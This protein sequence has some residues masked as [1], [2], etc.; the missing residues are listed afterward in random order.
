MGAKVHELKTPDGDKYKA[1]ITSINNC[2][3][4]KLADLFVHMFNGADDTL[5]HLAELAESNEDQ[6][7]YFDAMRMLRLEQEN[8]KDNFTAELE[9]YLQPINQK[10]SKSEEIDFNEEELT[11]V[12]QDT[13]EEMV[14]ISAMHS[15]AMGL[16]GDAVNHLEARLEVLAL[17]TTQI[18][19]KKSLQ[20]K[21]IGIS[22][23]S[24]LK[25][26][27]LSTKNKLILYKLFDQ[28]VSSKMEPC[29]EAINNLLIAEGILPQIKPIVSSSSSRNSHNNPQAQLRNSE[30][31]DTCHNPDEFTNKDIHP[32]VDTNISTGPFINNNHSDANITHPQDKINRVIHQ[33]LHGSTTPPDTQVN[34]STQYF[35][36][37]D[38]L[39]ALSNL[40]KDHGAGPGTGRSIDIEDFKRTLVSHMC[41]KQGGAITKQVNQLDEKTID[42]IEM[43]FEAVI[44]DNS[45]PEVITNLLLRLQ[46]PVIKAAMLD[47]EL[48]NNTNHPARSLLNLIVQAGKIVNDKNDKLYPLLETEI[49]KLLNSFDVDIISFQNAIDNINAFINEELSV[50]EE[51]ERITQKNALQE[52][53][54]IVVLN[55]MQYRLNG[56]KLPRSAHT[57]ILKLWSTLM[58]HR[59]IRNGKDS[60]SWKEASN[61]LVLTI[62]S[63]QPIKSKNSWLSLKNNHP[64]L[65]DTLKDYLHETKLNSEE[66]NSSLQSLKDT[67]D[68]MTDNSEFNASAELDTFPLD[69]QCTSNPEHSIEEEIT[70][71]SYPC[72]SQ[73][74]QEA[75]NNT[76]EFSVVTEENDEIDKTADIAREKIAHLPREVRPGVWFEIFNGDDRSVRRLKLSVIIMDEAKLIFV[77]RFGVKAIEKDATL[78]TEELANEKSKIIA[79]HS[80]FDAALGK[81]ITSLAASA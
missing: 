52:H 12:D 70:L 6:N 27:E 31:V 46:I 20:P 77:D 80:A 22:F 16:F 38:I 21:N 50:T 19:D 2:L 5:F 25:S 44:E 72:D 55:E 1:L 60:A 59:Y 57:L 69:E 4:E 61:I 15:K 75:I 26:V 37:R 48:F 36:R 49:D 78:F 47:E 39:K 42:F 14:A 45:V 17:K 3:N 24:A 8:I 23:L 56:K 34:N 10:Q 74:L 68:L 65:I 29:Y 40:Q 58:F 67:Y 71:E 11:L 9:T 79:D 41:S 32:T 53:A 64:G 66:I 35:D 33:F 62:N 81:V 54:R 76:G 7:H 13:M 28:E 43:L 51:N 63:L 18:F 30:T 73:L